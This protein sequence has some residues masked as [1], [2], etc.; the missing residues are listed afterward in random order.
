MPIAA[1]KALTIII[2][3]NREVNLFS[4]P[5]IIKILPEYN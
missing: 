1:R 3:W 5:V 4:I 2:F